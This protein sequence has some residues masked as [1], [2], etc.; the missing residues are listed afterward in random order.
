MPIICSQDC[1][2][3]KGQLARRPLTLD[4]PPRLQ[5]DMG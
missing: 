2:V 4:H 5:P 1:S 3:Y